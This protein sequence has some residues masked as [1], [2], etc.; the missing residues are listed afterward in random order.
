MNILCDLGNSRLKWAPLQPDGTPGAVRALVHDG[1]EFMD[2]PA[3]LL[4]SGEVAWL[5]SVASPALQ[6][7]L[8][9]VLGQRF[10]RIGIAR[11]QA[12]FGGVRIAYAHPE[13]LGV[14]RF[15]ALVAARARGADAWLL[16]GVGTALT[17]DLLDLHGR[18]RGGLVAPTPALMRESLQ[19]RAPQLPAAGGQVLDFADDTQDAL[20]SGCIGAALGLIERSRA[21]AAALLQTPPRLLLHGGGAAPLLDA[22][23]EAVS[24]PALVLEGL[25]RWAAAERDSGAAS[26]PD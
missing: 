19:A 4:P 18:H 20:A 13:R 1:V 14:D 12:Q 16:V 25:G 17:V 5:A 3:A 10:R 21:R 22:L 15:L 26:P 9:E 8:L 11:T 6:L 2:D 23:P 24:A 7:Q